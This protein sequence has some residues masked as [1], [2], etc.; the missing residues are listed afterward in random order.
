MTTEN[1]IISVYDTHIE[2]ENAIKALEKSG[3]DMK[4]LSIIGKG[5][6]TEEHPIGFYTMG[7]RIKTW[8]G[9][10][11]IWG[12]F[13]GLMFA[14]AIFFI[15]GVGWIALAGP[16]VSTLVAALESAALAGSVSAL[17][18]A[19]FSIGIHEDDVAK[20]EAAVKADK[21]ILILHGLEEE[22]ANA[23]KLL[24]ALKIEDTPVSDA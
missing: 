14:P 15:P 19:L 24:D 10:G 17:G 22:I 23:R 7:D 16:I 20:Y 6:N 21:Y 12:G 8:F 11:A 13:W 2:T 4:K 3:F 1:T 9:A 5:Y 18:A